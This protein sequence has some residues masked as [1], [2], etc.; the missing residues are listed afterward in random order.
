MEIIIVIGRIDSNCLATVASY[1]RDLIDSFSIGG[2]GSFPHLLP[3]SREDNSRKRVEDEVGAVN[4]VVM[5][6]TYQHLIFTI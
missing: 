1:L 4:G 5:I 6:N 3:K 2:Q